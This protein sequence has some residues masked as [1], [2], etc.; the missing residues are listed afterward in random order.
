MTQTEDA[1]TNSMKV[2]KLIL[3]EAQLTPSQREK[4][5]NAQ[6]EMMIN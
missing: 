5:I 4:V 3:N 2:R 6:H 1:V